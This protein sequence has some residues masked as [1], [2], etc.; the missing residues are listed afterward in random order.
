L[1]PDLSRPDM[2]AAAIVASTGAFRQEVFNLADLQQLIQ[3]I[4]NGVFV[5]P[6][7]RGIKHIF[8]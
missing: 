6:W 1:L 8:Q 3:Q 7:I 4:I 5:F 2:A